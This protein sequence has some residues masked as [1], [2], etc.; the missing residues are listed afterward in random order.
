MRRRALVAILTTLSMLGIL[1]GVALAAD[2]AG[3]NTATVSTRIDVEVENTD[4]PDVTDRTDDRPDVTTDRC[5]QR[6]VD[7]R[8]PDDTRPDRPVDRCRL[9][10]D[11]DR[12]CLDDRHP[13]VN[14]RAL[15]WRLIQAHEWEKLIRLLHWL[16]WL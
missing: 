9:L 4:R 13:H 5:V 10:A 12:R 16:G 15:I 8:C 11:L 14:V 6:L 3:D 2:R 7:R 1:P